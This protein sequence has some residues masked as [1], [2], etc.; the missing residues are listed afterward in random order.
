[1]AMPKNIGK[2]EQE[3]TFKTINNETGTLRHFFHY[4]IE[5]G[6]IEKNPC[7][8]IKKLNT[9]FRLKTLSDD[10]INKLI[11]QFTIKFFCDITKIFQK[12]RGGLKKRGR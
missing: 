1:M 9:L 11:R 8:G 6:L 10:D 5:K 3:I 4:C 12:A 7:T 2:K